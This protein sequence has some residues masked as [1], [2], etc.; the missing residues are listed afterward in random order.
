MSTLSAATSTTWVQVESEEHVWTP[1][2]PVCRGTVSRRW[3]PRYPRTLARRTGAEFACRG[4]GCSIDTGWR[5]A[6]TVACHGTVPVGTRGEA[7][8]SSAHLG[9]RA[10][11]GDRDDAVDG[12]ARPAGTALAIALIF[13]VSGDG[14]LSQLHRLAAPAAG[15][16]PR[17][18]TCVRVPQAERAEH[19]GRPRRPRA[20]DRLS[21]PHSFAVAAQMTPVRPAPVAVRRTPARQTPR[22][23]TR[24]RVTRRRGARG[25]I[26]STIPSPIL[27][28]WHKAFG[29]AHSVRTTASRGRSR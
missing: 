18:G 24:R 22:D 16:P 11:P 13:A 7:E 20:P 27:W 5:R 2:S 9:R 21:P 1:S 14:A 26:S 15:P 19:S 12:P 10:H 3:W 29:A 25:S 4:N 28:F 23:T 8:H 6:G 17:S